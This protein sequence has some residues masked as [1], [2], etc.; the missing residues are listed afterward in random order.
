MAV[1]SE[2]QT[3]PLPPRDEPTSTDPQAPKPVK[4]HAAKLTAAEVKIRYEKG[5]AGQRDLLQEYWLNHAFITGHQWL[6]Y[7]PVSYRIDEMPRDPDR[8]QMTVNRM[9]SIS[10]SLMSKLVQR[11]LKFD[12]V[13]TAVDD[14][15]VRG[16]RIGESA[17][18]AVHQDH[19]WE[20]LREEA[21]WL[22]WK[23]GTVGICVDWDPNLGELIATTAENKQAYD[24][25]TVET[26]LSIAEMVVEP[27]SHEAETARWWIKAQALP[28]SQVQATFKLAEL[29]AAD[30]NAG[31]APFQQK[32]LATSQGRGGEQIVD[33]T[34]VMTYYERPNQERPEGAVCT[35]VG[36]KVVDGPKPWPFP[37]KDHLNLVVA[38]ETLIEHRWAGDTVLGQARSIQ[39][40]Y[41]AS[42]SSIVEHMKLAGNA[43]LFVPQSAIDLMEQLTDNPGEMVP[44]VDGTQPP[45]WQSPP[46]MP[47]WWIEQP[48]EL[49]AA[50]DDVLGNH[51]VSR[52]DAPPN[53][54]SGYGLSILTENDESPTA[55][56]S[57]ELAIMWGKVASF[58][59]KI[60]EVE[61][62][63]ARESVVQT[64]GHSPE[65]ARWSGKDLQGQT[66]V[67]VPLDAVLPR[68]RA[69]MQ[70]MADKMLQMGVITDFAQYAKVAELPGQHDLIE[71]INPDVARARRENA[72]MGMGKQAVPMEI[73][74]HD[75]H[76]REHRNDM[77]S[78]RFDLISDEWK[79]MYYDHL[80]AHETMA[81]EAAARVANA[82]AINPALGAVPDRTGAPNP[83][84]ES[85]QGASRFNTTNQMARSTMPVGTL[86]TRVPHSAH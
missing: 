24:G 43:R 3:F 33:L 44:Y 86:P 68:S 13:P 1:P 52:G 34:M 51:D 84:L 35:V 65:T 21:A 26:V 19:N 30:I 17:I 53:I 10:R 55:R 46:Q 40:A 82:N 71:A 28:P 22:C 27:G 36:D 61:V 2:N 41:N 58:V 38:R 81:A 15:T 45:S 16:A 57:K 7:N 73:D 48:K 18:E 4:S 80:Q 54:Q 74:D 8:V 20:H 49:A 23:G 79:Q 69:A 72:N 12:V 50:M 29:P 66:R 62:T 59:L 64:P 67:V 47:A 31:M 85:L 75:I 14:S 60:Y 70:A 77:K 56:L 5:L 83:N 9:R 42:W 39:V 76:M 25:D 11:E 63:S 78:P 6:W 32:L 37:W